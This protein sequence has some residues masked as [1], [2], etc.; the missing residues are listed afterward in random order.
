MG[1]QPY[2]SYEVYVS[3][4]DDMGDTS[5]AVS[6]VEVTGDKGR[7]ITVPLET[8]YDPIQQKVHLVYF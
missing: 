5:E 4:V 8:I 6:L 1:L 2:S 3:S 7:F